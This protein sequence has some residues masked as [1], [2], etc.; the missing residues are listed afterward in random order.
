MPTEDD[1]FAASGQDT[2]ARLSHS[3]VL[4]HF[5]EAA[6][7]YI[8]YIRNVYPADLFEPRKLYNVPVRMSRHPTLNSYIAHVL[9]AVR[10]DLLKGIVKKIYIPILNPTTNKPVEKFTFQIKDL[11]SGI[12]GEALQ[13][14]ETS[15]NASDIETYLRSFLLKIS[16]CESMLTPNPPNCTFCIM[17]ELEELAGPPSSAEKD[18]PWVHG[19]E[20]E[21]RVPQPSMIPLKTMDAG[22]IKMQLFVEEA[23]EKSTPASQASLISD[24]SID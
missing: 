16:V 19:E 7:H 5:L 20:S 18:V 10:P 17:M 13:S 4:V 12:E 3:D 22:I 11:L 23:D 24:R 15:V 21:I 1:L 8:L 14:T 9:T 2:E 6:I